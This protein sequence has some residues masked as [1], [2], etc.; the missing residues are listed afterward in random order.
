MN[1]SSPFS[2][3]HFETLVRNRRY[4]E[5]LS[6]LEQFR[7]A[8][9]RHPFPDLSILMERPFGQ[10]WLAADQLRERFLIRIAA[11]LTSV[12]SDEQLVLTDERMQELLKM[13]SFIWSIFS[14]APL[15]SADHVLRKFLHG[16]SDGTGSGALSSD[17]VRRLS[18]LCTPESRLDLDYRALWEQDPL[19]AVSLC[20]A[21]AGAMLP[22]SIA[23]YEQRD[24]LLAWLSETLGQIDDMSKLNINELAGLYMHCSYAGT[25]DRHTV[26]RAINT[27]TR[28]TLARWGWTDLETSRSSERLTS[29]KRPVMMVLAERFTM[30]H[31]IMRTHSRTISAA[32][33]KFETVL[34]SFSDYVDEFGRSLCDRFVDIGDLADTFGSLRRIREVA[35]AESPEVLYMPS[36]GMSLLTV[37]LSNVRV[38]PLQI[39][40][41]GHPAT[42][43]SDKI[44]FISVEDSYVG[45]PACFSEKLMRLPMDG[46]PYRPSQRL[47]PIIP[48]IPKVR[49][50]VDIAVAASLMKLNPRFLSACGTI[51]ERI[52]IAGRMHFLS[53]GGTIFDLMSLGNM[54]GR[55][56][57]RGRFQIHAV[58]PYPEYI[59]KLNDMDMFLSPFPFGNTNGIVDA[60]TVG[61]PGVC[62]TGP[63]VFEHIDGAMYMRAGMPG[64]LVADTVEEYIEAAV[65]LATHHEERVSLRKFMI[66]S[67]IVDRFFQGRPEVFGEMVLDLL[68]EQQATA[69]Q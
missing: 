40:A 36:V 22:G 20:I 51:L 44:D 19:T 52:G 11:A 7:Q 61:L 28:K 67:N 1:E 63:E 57:P 55:Y 65:R 17:V 27:L 25:P 62:K 59:N 33:E 14:A 38:A 35:Q 15:R 69:T 46:Q 53:S 18:I 42:T 10:P 64:W 31:S 13:R 41:V 66:E 16:P 48:R 50:Q 34:L 5:A 58:A 37:F 45:D 39:A 21:P 26:K 4:D 68:R 23:A 56:L 12:L 43:H 6:S 2:L 54:V 29:G 9:G 24:R 47:E 32:R 30:G 8:L 3:E 60:F 49:P